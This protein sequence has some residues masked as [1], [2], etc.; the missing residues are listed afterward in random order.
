[1]TYD[2]NTY[3]LFLNGSMTDSADIGGQVINSQSA[4]TIGYVQNDMF[5]KGCIDDVSLYIT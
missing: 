1:M 3:K 4:S 5:F 2:G